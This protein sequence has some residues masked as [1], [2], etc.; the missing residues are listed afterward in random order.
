MKIHDQILGIK[1]LKL[2]RIN[3]QH[4]NKTKIAEINKKNKTSYKYFP[5]IF[6]SADSQRDNY[7]ERD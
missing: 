1:P 7:F 3:Y 6:E 4:I 2:Y 5:Y